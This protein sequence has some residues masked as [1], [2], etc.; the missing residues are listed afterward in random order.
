M[1]T[2]PGLDEHVDVVLEVSKVFLTMTLAAAMP[3]ARGERSRTCGTV[4]AIDTMVAAAPPM[5]TVVVVLAS[6]RPEVGAADGDL[7]AARGVSAVSGTGEQVPVPF[8]PA[9]RPVTVGGPAAANAAIHTDDG[10]AG[11]AEQHCDGDLHDHVARD[12]GEAD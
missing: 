6:P 2:Q 9:A 7:V 5:V 10:E 11:E 8:K 12:L 1:Y 4:D 3:V